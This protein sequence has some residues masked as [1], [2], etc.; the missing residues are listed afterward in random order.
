MKPRFAALYIPVEESKILKPLAA[1]CIRFTPFVGVE[2]DITSE[3]IKLNPARRGLILD[4]TGTEHIHR[5]ES[6]LAQQIIEPLQARKIPIS[7]GIASTIGSAWALS[8][9]T[10]MPFSIQTRE[11]ISTLLSPYPVAALRLAPA[12]VSSMNEVGV[13]T[14][15]DLLALP[16]KQLAQR[17]GIPVLHRIDQALGR[18]HEPLR[19]IKIAEQLQSALRF[20]IPL[21]QQE[22]LQRCIVR[23][24][25]DLSEKLELGSQKASS[26][27]LRFFTEKKYPHRPEYI[28]L[29]RLPESRPYHLYHSARHRIAADHRGYRHGEYHGDGSQRV[30]QR[31]APSHRPPAR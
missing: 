2:P 23:L 18:M 5:S 30:S 1:W 22:S 10:G 12:Q 15:G 9:F 29:P 8:R 28:S 31:S 17:F 6:L 25:T 14:V 27:Q 20:D 21:T 11:T 7:V 16:A 3:E 4:I 13:F 24:L 19:L 26:Y